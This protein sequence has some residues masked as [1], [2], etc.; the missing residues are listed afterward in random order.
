MSQPIARS[1]SACATVSTASATISQSTPLISWITAWTIT[2]AF[3]L[4]S[5]SAMSDGSSL[6][7]SSGIARRRARFE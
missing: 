3:S 2:L 4:L 5:M 7:R 6:T 1:M